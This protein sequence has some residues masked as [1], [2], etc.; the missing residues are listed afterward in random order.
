[1]KSNRKR[2]QAQPTPQPAARSLLCVPVE[3]RRRGTSL[4]NL[5]GW[6]WGRDIC[7][8][9]GNLLLAHGFERHRPPKGKLGSSAYSLK[10]DSTQSVVLWGFGLLYSDSQHGA[11]YLPRCGFTPQLTSS[12]ELP[13]TIW[14][15]AQ[16]PAMQTPTSAGEWRC[17]LTL[18]SGALTWIAGYEHWITAN[19]GIEYRCQCV[20]EW[21]RSTIAATEIVVSWQQLA[22]TCAQRR[23]AIEQQALLTD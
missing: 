12:V 1:M 13:A 18:L 11:V 22:A 7:R 17:L 2:H 8:T 14:E 10:L 16:L 20:A 9:Q 19:F 21:K 3:V 23:Q 6:C 15:M 4:L 5:Q